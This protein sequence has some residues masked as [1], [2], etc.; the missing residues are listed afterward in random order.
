MASK[1]PQLAFANTSWSLLVDPAPM[2]AVLPSCR[3]RA[4]APVAPRSIDS[5]HCVQP[6]VSFFV[7]FEESIASVLIDISVSHMLTSVQ[8]FA[9]TKLSD[10]FG[11]VQGPRHHEHDREGSY[12]LDRFLQGKDT[13]CGERVLPKCRQNSLNSA[14]AHPIPEN[15]L[16]KT[17]VCGG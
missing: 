13:W 16:G 1:S 11:E 3:R 4:A 10:C 15:E 8:S 17:H 12:C 5:L 2:I 14:V 9:K 7:C 6:Y